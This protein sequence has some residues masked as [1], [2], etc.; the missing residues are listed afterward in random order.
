MRDG[1]TIE[2]RDAEN[3]DFMATMLDGR[4]NSLG[5]AAYLTALRPIYATL[6]SVGRRLGDSEVGPLI[7]PALERLAALDADLAFWRDR[8]DEPIPA[9]ADAAVE[10]Y[11]A[12]LR[13][14]EA[15]PALFAAHHYT[16][17]LGDLSGGQAIGRILA[18]SYGLTVDGPGLAFYRFASIGK[19]KPYKDGYRARLDE[20]PFDP[21]EQVRIVEEV[22]LAFGLNAA[23]FTALTGRLSEF[24]R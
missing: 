13:L 4:I 2:H 1:S 24:T 6:E 9:V 19:L 22:R 21:D 14:T 20:L 8:V 11:Q 16:R 15:D 17:Y 12:R 3:S 5:Y 23:I 7:D 10:R 18:R